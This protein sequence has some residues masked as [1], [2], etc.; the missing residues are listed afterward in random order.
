MSGWGIWDSR[1]LTTPA[2][3]LCLPPPLRKAKGRTGAAVLPM[4]CEGRS[5]RTLFALTGVFE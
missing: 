2:A 1:V 4:F 3:P 5:T